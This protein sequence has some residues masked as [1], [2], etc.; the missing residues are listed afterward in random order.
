MVASGIR[1]K[2][3]ADCVA[4][5]NR[6]IE[7]S[8]AYIVVSSTWRTLGL[9]TM[10]DHLLEW[11]VK[12]KVLDVTPDLT[13]KHGALYAGATRGAEIQAWLDNYTRHEIE[14]LVILDDDSDMGALMPWLVKTSTEHGLTEA[15]AGLAIK[16]LSVPFRVFAA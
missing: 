1:A 9:I 5:L 11:G 13:R 6:I 10:K 3:D 12:C 4:H 2:A 14:S 7:E 8:D 15:D 16:K